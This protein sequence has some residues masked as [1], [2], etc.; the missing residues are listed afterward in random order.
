VRH[1][2]VVTGGVPL[3]VDDEPVLLATKL[4]P[5]ARRGLLARPALVERLRP[6]A[7]RLTV[8]DAP[9]GWG[10]TSLLAEW[11]AV[12]SGVRLAWVSLDPH[13]DHPVLFWSYVLAGLRRTLPGIGERALRAL[14][15]GGRALRDAALPALVND[16]VGQ[17]GPI[18]LVLDDYQVITDSAVHETVTLL[19][20]RLPE[21][22]HVVVATRGNP[23]LP[24][25]RLRAAGELLELRA[26]DLAFDAAETTRVLTAVP[27]V[28]LGADEVDRLARRTEGWPAG[29]ALAAASL[30][31]RGAD[32]SAFVEAFTGTDRYVLDYLGTEV[33]AHLPADLR[34]FVL[35]T[36]ILRRLSPESCRAVTG[37]PDSAAL[38]DRAERAGVFLSA[39]DPG[40]RWFR[41]HRL[42]GELLRHELTRVEPTVVPTLHR[43]AAAW[44]TEVGAIG[45]AVAHHVAA[46][47]VHDAAELV[48]GCW[49]EWFN[50]G[51]L[52]SVAG[53]LDLLP[54]PRIRADPRLCVARAW[55]LLDMGRLDEV[56]RWIA[57]GE[58]AG[59]G[60]VAAQRDLAVLRATHGF[61]IGNLGATRAAARRVLEL[62]D[63]AV[64]FA[65]TV[66]HLQL[67]ITAFWSGEVAA[68]I[69][70][71][72]EA[73]RMARRTDN[74]LAE[75]YGLG[76]LA[77]VAAD[78]GDLDDAARRVP[79]ALE[80]C[81]DPGV[82]EHFVA[83]LPH[84]ACATLLA[85]SGRT[86]GAAA[87]AARA[88]TLA[89]RGAGLL[90]LSLALAVRARTADEH[91]ARGLLD[92]ARRIARACPDP[93]PLP[94]RLARIRLGPASLGGPAAAA[95][96]GAEITLSERERELLPL[97]AGTLSQRE[98]G[99]VL[100]LSLNTVKT[101]GRVLFRKL[102]VSSRAEAVARAR[103][104]GLL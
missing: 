61:K 77:L 79:L 104:L 100:H 11:C 6:T 50:A 47:D 87:A 51:R 72:A 31:G 8:L 14:P 80:P 41:Y 95:G 84:L 37:R 13:D 35:R 17:P 39:I 38:L 53:W 55:L 1:A 9:A 91:E 52:G 18:V 89:C 10:K 16:L 30:A 34:E 32:V 7:Y 74:V 49:T 70:S 85:A 97:L 64:S 33:L 67:G 27:G 20:E 66:A 71:L 12:A 44:S 40:R 68:A 69:R 98:I 5:P 43:R 2:A 26:D 57:C 102:G 29:V 46:G 62:D 65:A 23:P 73:V 86:E 3:P 78:S 83:A 25:G 15:A 24:L 19:V 28:D 93:G 60:D 99:S 94:S 82:G 96:C 76:Y 63:G 36:S 4:A 75:T 90:E 21:H 59:G 58:G 42:F 48:A 56:G 103:E 101:H 22:V 45:D 88:L 81:A 92:E 54:E